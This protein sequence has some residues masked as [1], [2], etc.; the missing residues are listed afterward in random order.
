MGVLVIGRVAVCGC[1]IECR[2]ILMWGI[3]GMLEWGNSV[4]M[5][6]YGGFAVCMS[7]DVC[8]VAVVTAAKSLWQNLMNKCF[9]GVVS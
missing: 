3:W 1:V 7:R 6:Q 8:K 9:S 5:S 2:E 4:L